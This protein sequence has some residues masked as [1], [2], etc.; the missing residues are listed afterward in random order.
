MELD[1][2]HVSV[3]SITPFK[4]IVVLKVK[5]LIEKKMLLVNTRGQS[6]LNFHN[7]NF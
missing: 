6:D 7:S 5:I 1:L 3:L 4:S 2:L